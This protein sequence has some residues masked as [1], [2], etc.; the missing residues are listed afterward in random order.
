MV[1]GHDGAT[2]HVCSARN[3]LQGQV[4][5]Q[6]KAQ[7][8]GQTT[9]GSSSVHVSLQWLADNGVEIVIV[10][11]FSFLVKFVEHFELYFFS[12]EWTLMG[13]GEE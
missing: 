13:F 9:F 6:Q 1:V 2:F 12:V 5:T 7:P 4:E 11:S 3:G 8:E 10:L